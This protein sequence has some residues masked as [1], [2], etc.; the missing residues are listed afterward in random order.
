MAD[1][2]Q[3]FRAGGDRAIPLHAIRGLHRVLITALPQLNR[4]TRDVPGKQ[5]RHL[6]GLHHKGHAETDEQRGWRKIVGKEPNGVRQM[7]W[8]PRTLR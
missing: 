8:V 7:V 2:I 6:D 5:P 1:S 4:E 3:I